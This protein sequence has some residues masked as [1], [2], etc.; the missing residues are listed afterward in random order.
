[1][2]EPDISIIVTVHAEGLLAHKTMLSVFGAAQILKKKSISYEIIVHMDTATA[3]TKLYFSRYRSNSDVTILQNN[4]SDPGL[5]RNYAAKHAHGK[6]LAFLDGDDLVSS[7]WYLEAYNMLA[8]SK[9][10]ILVHPEASLTFGD[11]LSEHILW[12]QKDSLDKLQ[13]ATI[14]VS[15]NRWISVVAGKKSTFLNTPYPASQN[16]FGNEDFWFNTETLAKDIRHVIAP[17]TVDFYRQKGNNSV[18]SAN[19]H[20]AQPYTNLLDIN[21]LKSHPLSSDAPVNTNTGLYGIAS[22]SFRKLKQ[23]PTFDQYLS[24][25]ARA[26]VKGINSKKAGSKNTSILPQFVSSACREASK[27]EPLL[28]PSES[29]EKKVFIYNSEYEINAGL[30]YR[31][32]IQNVS[33]YPNYIFIVPWVVSGGADKVLLNYLNA[34]KE[35]HPKWKIAVITTLPSDN[36]WASRLPD[37]SYLLDFGNN[38]EGFSPSEKDAL[39]SRLIIQLKCKKLHII[40]SE[41]G[42]LWA[43]AHLDLIKDNNYIL[44][45]SLFC[46]DIIPGT[47][48][49][50]I[51]DYANPYL[52]NI[53]SAVNK[54]FTDNK[55]VISRVVQ[56]DG[57]D[58]NKFVVEYQPND[59]EIVAPSEKHKS[60]DGK[61]HILWASRVATQKNPELLKSIAR[62]LDPSKYQ[63]DV[64]GRLDNNYHKSFFDG[65]PALDYRGAY[66]GIN[67]LD[68]SRYDVFLYTSL[69]DGLPNILLEITALGLPIIASDAGGI[70]EFIK[71]NKTGILVKDSLS[72]DAYISA[73]NQAAAHPD[74]LQDYLASAQ[75]LLARQHSFA[76]YLKKISEDF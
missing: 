22:R 16:G 45:T 5:S 21:R 46:H 7:N 71:N 72:K 63:I 29:L 41:Y 17:S 9:E 8:S 66:D 18:Y 10:E 56:L 19:I 24:P 73:I 50:G 65:I 3:E 62:S 53:F 44:N 37:N 52:L 38:I 64:Y 1:M 60:P 32:I 27:I 26:V 43:A 14:S 68:F 67:S 4:F 6:Y 36:S 70:K 25:L 54:V 48:G 47:N 59:L 51:F 69:I 55:A 2:V 28:F 31:R 13:D 23:N 76:T 15:T 20:K 57:F 30:A 39:F 61:F 42:Y 34:F 75:K 11:N 40:N 49:Q 35:L 58:E 74:L 33:D 12:L